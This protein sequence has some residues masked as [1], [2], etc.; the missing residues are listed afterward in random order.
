[1]ERVKEQWYNDDMKI[2]DLKA[3]LDMNEELM[4][5]FETANFILKSR[6][7]YTGVFV[8]ESKRTIER[9]R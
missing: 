9:I 3:E 5:G 2:S 8:D 6:S 7:D 1:M 4:A